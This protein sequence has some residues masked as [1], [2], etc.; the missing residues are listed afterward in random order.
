MGTVIDRPLSWEWLRAQ[1]DFSLSDAVA[2]WDIDSTIMDTGPRNYAILQSATELFPRLRPYIKEFHPDR[3]GWNIL[4]PLKAH[5]AED[6]PLLKDLQVYWES[7]FFSDPWLK[8]DVPYP[9]VVSLLKKMFEEGIRL[10]YLTG[11]DQPNMSRGTVESFRQSGI[12]LGE[13]T[14]F[15]FKP[16]FYTPDLDYK[17]SCLEKIRSRGNVVLAVENEPA[18][19]NLFLRAFPNALVMH[20]QSISSPDP[21]PLNPGIIGFDSYHEQ[22]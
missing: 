21:E 13:T 22:Y 1:A 10:I 19:A 6:D 7:C 18:N 11:R 4:E 12:P 2:V 16:D 17:K 15:L 5:F 3:M 20:F 9:G 8:Y 14:E